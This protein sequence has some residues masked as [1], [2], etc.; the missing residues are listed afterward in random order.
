MIN[1]S[2]IKHFIQKDS[3]FRKNILK[4]SFGGLK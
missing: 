2:Q 4:Q 1:V 3:E